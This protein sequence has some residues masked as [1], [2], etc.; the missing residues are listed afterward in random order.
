MAMRAT[1]AQQALKAH[2]NPKKA[3]FVARYFKSGPGEYGEGDVFIG[4]PVP[5]MRSV[6]KQFK[7]LSQTH[8]LK[9]L[10]SPIHE[11]RY[12]ALIILDLQFSKADEKERK[13][14][15]D[16]YLGNLDY[17]NN[18]DLVDTSAYPI[19]GAYLMSRSRSVLYKL[20]RSKD[21]WR[22]RVAIIAT[23]A[24]IRQ[25]D[26]SDTLKLAETLLSHE[27]D[28]IHKA[29]GWMLREVANRDRAVAEVFLKRHCKSMPRTM[30]RYAIEKFPE[31]RR[32]AYLKG[33][34]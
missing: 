15:V 5:Q 10:H 21:L 23:Y 32:R 9:L 34:I 27:H 8:I 6:A 17:V 28:L 26:F 2:A 19:L 33:K 24:F 25:N 4:V 18:W 22:Q 1:D 11:H 3:E 13:R 16:L 20:A 31:S 7:E 12:T 30:L 29:V 14:I